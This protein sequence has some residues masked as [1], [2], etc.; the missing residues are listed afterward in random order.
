MLKTREKELKITSLCEEFF[1]F[2]SGSGGVMRDTMIVT[3]IPIIVGK[4]PSHR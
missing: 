4:A 3:T 1:E 2:S